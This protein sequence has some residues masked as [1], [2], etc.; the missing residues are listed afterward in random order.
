MRQFK[1][2]SDN[3]ELGAQKIDAQSLTPNYQ[4]EYLTQKEV[5]KILR[6]S[7]PTLYRWE[8]SA[9]VKAHRIGC[10]VLYVRQEIND[11]VLKNSITSPLNSG[12]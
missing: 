6:I 3:Q 10:R 9:I 1:R 12:K 5:L 2:L 4:P 8:R 11:A 7:S